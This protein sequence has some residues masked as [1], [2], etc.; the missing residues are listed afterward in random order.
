MNRLAVGSIANNRKFISNFALVEMLPSVRFL[1][2]QRHVVS[3]AWPVQDV[4][5]ASRGGRWTL[6]RPQ[7]NPAAA[8]GLGPLQ[9]GVSAPVSHC[10]A[11]GRIAAERAEIKAIAPCGTGHMHFSS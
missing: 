11:A 3:M 6:C 2:R 8:A 4:V 10:S 7:P 1:G 5:Q 9:D